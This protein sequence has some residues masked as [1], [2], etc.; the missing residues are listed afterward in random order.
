M[1][2]ASVREHVM[3]DGAEDDRIEHR[4]DLQDKSVVDSI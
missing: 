2:L 1:V 3:L 4:H